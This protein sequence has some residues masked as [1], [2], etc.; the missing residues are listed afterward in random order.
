MPADLHH[1]ADD[2]IRYYGELVRRLSRA[3]VRDV[4][5]LC[6]LYERLRTALEAVS[7]QE[8][9]WATEQA[10]GVIDALVGVQASLTALR[11]LKRTIGDDWPSA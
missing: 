3:G 5:E 9:A 1:K 8:I 2:L 7:G 6:A 4:A 10:R 11:T